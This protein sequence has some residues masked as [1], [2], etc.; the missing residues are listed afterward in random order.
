MFT[1][2]TISIIFLTL[3]FSSTT[4]TST[5]ICQPTNIQ[6]SIVLSPD[7]SLVAGDIIDLHVRVGDQM[8][9]IRP[10]MKPNFDINNNNNNNDSST[11]INFTDSF[12]QSPFSPCHPTRLTS[13]INPDDWTR[14]L[15][16]PVAVLDPILA[17]DEFSGKNNNNTNTDIPKDTTK[18]RFV[19]T[20]QL[21]HV[22]SARHRAM[23]N[24]LRC[25]CH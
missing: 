24:C 1:L 21:L 19:S 17:K 11:N 7:I 13:V 15:V 18:S 12:N 25:C 8:R 20:I 16:I 3:L 14:F 4:T 22:K 9:Y 23:H 2:H 6:R 5:L 10:N